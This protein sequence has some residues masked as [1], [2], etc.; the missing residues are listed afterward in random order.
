MEEIRSAKKEEFEQVIGLINHVFR[1]KRGHRLTMKEEF[2]LLLNQ[3]NIDNLVG[4]YYNGEL[5]SEVNFLEG[6]VLM[7]DAVVKIASIGGVCTH[8]SYRGKDY[9]SRV[10]NKVEEIVYEKGIDI[11]L[12]SGERTLYTRRQFMKVENF[13]EYR[14]NPFCRG[15]NASNLVWTNMEGKELDYNNSSLDFEGYN[16]NLSVV[17]YEEKHL[18][19]MVKMYNLNNVR[20]KRTYEEFKKLISSATMAWGNFTYK[21]YVI[22]EKE[23]CIGYIILRII[24]DKERYGEVVEYFGD[25]KYMH[26]ILE[27][28]AFNLSLEHIKHYVHVRDEINRLKDCNSI[29]KRHL[30]GTV[31][32]INYKSFMEHLKPYFKQHI[33]EDIL[34]VL[35]FEE[36]ERGYGII[37]GEESLYINSIGEITKLIFEGNSNIETKEGL[38]YNLQNKPFIKRFI[39]GAFPVPFVWTANL[40]YQ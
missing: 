16:V 13:Y 2:P 26:K 3:D 30:Q 12:V 31:K 33:E 35:K 7:E 29:S 20:Y 17:N 14:L 40:N 27:D 8:E 37:I 1:E 25:A 15:K 18:Y 24:E 36:S 19:T 5:I 10:L 39:E 22:L 11:A 32:I 23:V 34:S 4:A 38:K 9:A 6:E 28:I 21:R